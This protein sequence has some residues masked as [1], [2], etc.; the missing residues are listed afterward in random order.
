MSKRRDQLI[1]VAAAVVVVL[2]A[3]SVITAVLSAERNGRRAL[4]DLQLAQLQQ[5]AR[6][7]DSAIG[8]SL[9]STVGLT[10]PS[11][12]L[13][14]SFAP[15]DASDRAGL[16]RLQSGQPTA[17]TGYVLVDRNGV[18][19]NGTLL[20]ESSSIGRKLDRPGLD[21]VLA[22]TPAV[23]VVSSASLTTPLPT[24]AIARPI[25]NGT[26]GPV[27]GA[28][29]QESDVAPDSLFT[30]LI[31]VFRRARTDEYSFLDSNGVVVS[32]TTAASVGK[33]ADAVLLDR[34]PGFHR[35]GGIVT[36]TAAIPSVGWTA[37]FRQ[38]TSEFEGDL[39]G[40]LRSALLLL[41][42]VA[43]LGGGLTFFVLLSRLR[44]ARREQARLAA[45]NNAREEF[46]SIVSHELRTPATGQLGFLQ[47]L[48]DHWDALSDSDRRQTVSQA[49]ANARRLHALSRDV[50]STAS[51]EAGELPY[52]FEVLDLREAVETSI[53]GVAN[54]DHEIVISTVDEDVAVR[55][56]PERI[57]Q[58]LANVLD[59][60]MK[61]SPIASR[62]DVR[63][64]VDGSDALVEVSDRGLGLTDEALEGSFE[65]FSRG[66]NTGV[67]GTGLGLYISRMI[68]N[69]HGGRIWAE[70]RQ[71]GGATIAFA[72]PLVVASAED[73]TPLVPSPADKA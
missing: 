6:V 59:N 14:W 55:A 15:N 29:L 47:T 10:N 66:R 30:Q 36:A 9:T 33:P 53:A 31:T 58:V 40:P 46:M 18:V 35:H 70:R 34:D 22:G 1:A 5:L 13:P 19:T 54:P 52:A 62:I 67:T 8:P 32:S 65:R 48:L 73:E 25:R 23:L 49:Y 4:E 17:R 60:A 3:A 2:L 63:V 43:A 41:A 69:A 44:A 7:L 71:G 61:N 28:I 45:I 21:K 50:L 37:T 12:N 64:S 72:L 57:Q 38:S 11:T 56:D 16:E 51:I 27:I 68:V 26:D 39:T 24:I 42:I 20:T